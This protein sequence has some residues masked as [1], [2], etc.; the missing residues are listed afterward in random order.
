MGWFPVETPDIRQGISFII[1][2]VIHLMLTLCLWVK[3][4]K[5]SNTHTHTH[6]YTWEKNLYIFIELECA[7]TFFKQT[8]R[9]KMWIKI[10]LDTWSYIT[11]VMWLDHERRKKT[12]VW[13]KREVVLRKL[14]PTGNPTSNPTSNSSSS[15]TITGRIFLPFERCINYSWIMGV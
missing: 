15:Q 10:L 4:N 6:V 14:A 12:D 2:E 1:I 13:S 9:K 8:W 3:T 11:P 7:I 5:D